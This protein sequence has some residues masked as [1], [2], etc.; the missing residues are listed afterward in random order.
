MIKIGQSW[1]NHI[2]KEENLTIDEFR[3]KYHITT[4]EFQFHS[5]EDQGYDV[6]FEDPKYE[7]L[8]KLKL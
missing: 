8:F 3:V 7:T 4:F 5:L 2:I 6:Y 1:I